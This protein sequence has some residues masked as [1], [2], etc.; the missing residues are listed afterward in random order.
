M[1]AIELAPGEALCAGRY[2]LQERLGAGGM[3][4]VWRAT[5]GHLDRPVAVKILSDTL[6]GDDGY[7]A[8]FRRESRLAASLSHPRLVQIFDFGEESGRPFLVMELVDGPTLADLLRRP[9]A[10]AVESR[11]LAVDLL[12]ALAH[13]HEAGI[14]HRDVKPAN[15]LMA[16][17]G[18]A[19]LTDFGIAQPPDA[20]QLTGTGLV[21]GTLRYLA[22]E[23]IEGGPATVRTDLFALGRL[24]REV[25]D[26]SH[27]DADAD[28]RGLIGRLIREDPAE[29]PASADEARGLLGGTAP[30]AA[31]ATAATVATAATAATVRRPARRPRQPRRVPEAV[32]V[33]AAPERVARRRSDARARARIGSRSGARLPAL[34]AAVLVA[35]AIILVVALVRSG[36]SGPTTPRAAPASAPLTRQLDSISRALDGAAR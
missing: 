2:R 12:E 34:V 33:N 32:A 5:D 11:E 10:L 26:H 23:L 31:A 21:I 9:A 27:R 24:L 3:A 25:V 35:G 28:L 22:P 6:A 29:R 7:V 30:T 20:T 19:R 1:A 36:G 14:V 17:D 15:V 13:V 18:R 8:R 4:S 16:P